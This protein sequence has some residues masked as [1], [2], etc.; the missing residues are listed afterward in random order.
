M[1]RIK[2][3]ASFFALSLVLAFIGGTAAAQSTMATCEAETE[4]N[5]WSVEGEL[6]GRAHRARLRSR[7]QGEH[8]AF[9]FASDIPVAIR[10]SLVLESRLSGEGDRPEA[11]H[12]ALIIDGVE[13]VQIPVPRGELRRSWRD[14]RRVASAALEMEHDPFW[15]LVHQLSNAGHVVLDVRADGAALPLTSHVLDTTGV[16]R[17]VQGQVE[18]ANAIFR[19]FGRGTCW[20]RR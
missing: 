1:T 10:Q 3:I 12:Y 14:N 2:S 18:Q 19:R 15:V 4:I 9:D 13:A 11:V 20:P 7:S 16:D 17:I 8:I 6:Y 5:G